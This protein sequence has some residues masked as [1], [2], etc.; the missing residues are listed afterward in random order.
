MKLK[1]LWIDGFKNLNNFEIDFTDK[2]GIT[3][4]IGNNGSGKSNVLEAISEIFTVLFSKKQSKFNYKLEYSFDNKITIISYYKER[5]PK[6]SYIHD[7]KKVQQHKRDDY[8]PKNIIT[9]YSGE[10]TRL[11]DM[12]YKPSYDVFLKTLKENKEYKE[13]KLFYVDSDYWNQGLATLIYADT[14]P[15]NIFIKE[16]LNINIINDISIEFNTRAILRYK[17]NVLKPFLSIINPE[18][19]KSISIDLKNLHKIAG[20]YEKDFFNI[21]IALTSL[22][23]ITKINIQFNNGLFTEDLSEGQKKQILIKVALDIIADEKSLILLDEPDSSIHVSNKQKIKNLLDEYDNRNTI[24]TTHSPTLTHHFPD[25]HITMI[26][27]GQIEDKTK[28]EIFSHISDGIWNYQEQSVFLSSTK[29]IILL[30]EG[31]HDKIHIEEAFKRVKDSYADLNFEVFNM[32]GVYNIKNFMSGMKKSFDIF[33]ESKKYIGIFDYDEAGREAIYNNP[34]RKKYASLK[35]NTNFYHMY[36]PFRSESEDF[37]IESMYSQDIIKDAYKKA[38]DDIS[39]NINKNSIEDKAKTN[40]SDNCKD[41]DNNDFEHF[42]KL[43]D[44]I[45]KIRNGN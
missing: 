43:F 4:L 31:K 33:D 5:T 20:Y 13:Q 22:N 21:L 42:K 10:E 29:D 24:L 16:S 32:H 23:L 8:L 18:N 39:S 45:E 3:V 35:G 25:N 34:I 1:R 11:W 26:N 38:I 2:D 44:L 6:F 17:D 37:E 27:D 36:L 12:Y 40:L 41:F 7:K 28:Q 9:L 30:V 14:E 15:N 19:I